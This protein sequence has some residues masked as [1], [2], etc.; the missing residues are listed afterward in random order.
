MLKKINDWLVNKQ[1]A[2][3]QQQELRKA[4]SYYKLVKAGATF[5]QFVQEDLK[6]EQ[7][8]LNRHTRRRME[9]ELNDKG[10]LTPELVQYYQQK[11]DWVLGNVNM[12]LNPP[13]P[14][15]TE[16]KDVESK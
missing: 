6:R 3:Q 13:K 7:Q 1:K 15:K 2:L 16:K 12:R 8:G 14:V 10:V 4:Q 9:K 11:I 5:I